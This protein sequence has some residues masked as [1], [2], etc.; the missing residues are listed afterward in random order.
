MVRRWLWT[1]SYTHKQSHTEEGFITPNLPN[2]FNDTNAVIE[3]C[4]AI[5]TTSVLKQAYARELARRIADIHAFY[6]P[7][8]DFFS[9]PEVSAEDIFAIANATAAQRATALV[10]VIRK[11]IK[12]EV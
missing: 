1:R 2:Y 6:G 12:T 4:N 3:A 11:H 9:F 5:L 7:M 8:R 10:A